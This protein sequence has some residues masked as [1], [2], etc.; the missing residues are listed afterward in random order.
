MERTQCNGGRR[1]APLIHVMFNGVG[2]R[3]QRGVSSHPGT[4]RNRASLITRIGYPAATSHSQTPYSCSH[5]K[6]TV[7]ITPIHQLF[8]GIDTLTSL[9]SHGNFRCKNTQP[10][11]PA[12][13]R[14]YPGWLKGRL[15]VRAVGCFASPPFYGT[16][17]VKCAMRISFIG[18]R[19]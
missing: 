13:S 17:F 7:K 10:D 6:E 3:R 14:C 19:A 11:A 8:L 5:Q 9:H 2:D 18:F 16:T 12:G 15:S 1:A 4:A